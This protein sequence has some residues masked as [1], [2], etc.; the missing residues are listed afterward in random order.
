MTGLH[1]I[2]W[3]GDCGLC[4][5]LIEWVRRKD[6]CGRFRDAPYRQA[7]SPPMTPELERACARAVHVVTADGR[8]LRA[9]R[10]SLFVLENIGWGGTARMLALP[11]FI[12]IVELGYRIVA[13]N[14]PLLSRFLFRG[15]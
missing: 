10:A 5:R 15:A 8:V 3:D 1:W 14:R 11:P 2:L 7:P 13:A 6:T 4:R 9:G 12:W